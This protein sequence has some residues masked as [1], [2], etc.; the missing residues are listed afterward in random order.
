MLFNSFEFILV[1]LP[2]VVALYFLCGRFGIRAATAFLGLA[3]LIFYTWWKI[4]FLP[5]LC[6]SI[7]LNYG[8]GILILR[9]RGANIGRLILILAISLDLAALGFYKYADFLI[10][11]ANHFGTSWSLLNVALPIGISFFTFTQ[12]AFLVDTWRGHAQERGFINY[13]LFVSYF[14]HLIAGPMLHHS[15]VMPQFAN[16]LAC[17]PNPQAITIGLLFFMMGLAKKVL[18]ADSFAPYAAGVFD[19]ASPLAQPGLAVAWTGALAYTFQIYFDFSGYCDMAIGISKILG[20]DLPIN[21]NSPYKSRNIIEFWRRWHMTLSQFL[22][23]Y[24]YIPLG[25]NKKSNTRRYANLMIT[26]LLG[27]L[28]HGASWNFVVWGALHGFYLAANHLWRAVWTSRPSPWLAPRAASSLAWLATFLAVIIAWVIFRAHDLSQAQLVLR[29]MAGLNG[30][31][32]DEN[33]LRLAGKDIGSGTKFLGM[34]LLALVLI[35]LPNSQTLAT[36]FKG[37]LSGSS[38]PPYLS[39][40]MLGPKALTRALPASA[41]LAALLVFASLTML[42]R[43]SEFLYFQF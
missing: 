2:L 13:V 21:F 26:M 16:P 42:G 38:R 33:M 8:A 32:F 10:G 41:F 29:G 24:L 31:S 34:T 15:Q 43:K 36:W 39:G 30:V 11:A 12:I 9:H 20:V 40:R 22:R 27:G 4:E 18:I 17:R 5:V 3:S 23:D 6:I 37:V 28:W 35:A 25:G 19:H 7:L 1:Y 14:P